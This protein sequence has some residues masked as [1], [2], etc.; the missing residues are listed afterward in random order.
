MI[1]MRMLTATIRNDVRKYLLRNSA[2]KAIPLFSV[3]SI[4]NQS[5]MWMLWCK[6]IWVFTATFMI[7]SARIISRNS[8]DAER[9]CLVS[10]LISLV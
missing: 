10:L 6:Y 9:A 5:V 7:W 1:Y 8:I 3:K 2:P 4:W